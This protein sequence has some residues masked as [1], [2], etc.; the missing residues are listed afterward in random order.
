MELGEGKQVP[1]APNL[2]G[3]HAMGNCT[4]PRTTP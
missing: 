1:K 4:A 3:M 2:R